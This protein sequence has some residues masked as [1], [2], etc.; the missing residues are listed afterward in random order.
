M[1]REVEREREREDRSM[2]TSMC[3]QSGVVRVTLRAL[4]MMD[5]GL[6]MTGSGLPPLCFLSKASHRE[7]EWRIA[8]V[9]SQIPLQ[10][11]RSRSGSGV[12]NFGD[13]RRGEILAMR[14]L[15]KGLR[16]F[17]KGVTRKKITCTTPG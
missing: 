7:S 15:V 6:G 9:A 13:F 11:K 16:P 14:P 3:A 5:L 2:A 10:V 17:D 1:E 8:A 12:V 4:G